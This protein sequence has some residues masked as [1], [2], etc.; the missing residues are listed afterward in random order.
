[1]AKASSLEFSNIS[2]DF[3]GVRALDEVSFTASASSVHG[4]IGENG[5]GKSTLLKILGGIYPASSGTV[6]LDGS[7]RRFEN[8]QQA[9]DAGISLIHQELQL[10]DEMTVEENLFLGHMPTRFGIIHK[11]L[12][13]RKALE[14]LEV[15]GEDI[16][17]SAK[18]R[19]LSIAKRQMV[20]V[21]KALSRG[22][23]IIAFD[24]PTSSLTEMETKRLFAII[25]G[26]KQGGV[27]VIYVSHR[28]EEV[29]R[30]CDAVTI[31][32]DGKCVDTVEVRP[33]LE[34]DELIRKMV[35]REISDIYDYRP[36][37]IGEAALQVKGLCG[38]GLTRPVDL[39]VRA[40]EIVGLFGLVGAGRTELM[41]LIYGA[42]K[43]SS[44]TVK[45]MG[46]QV[47]IN[48]P[49]DAINCGITFCPEDRK[50]EGLVA[51][52]SVKDNVNI[53]ARRL[54]TKM[55]CLVDNK[56]ELTNAE[57]MSRKLA[58]KTPSVYQQVKNLSG[59][60]QQKVILAR[61]LCEDISVMLLDEPTRGIDV[62][63]KNEIYGILFGL[64]SQ[65]KAVLVASSEMQEMLGICDRVLVVRQGGIVASVNRED[66]TEENLLK[67]ALPVS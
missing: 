59:G 42:V 18:I 67:L 20:E 5:A 29:L 55:K 65:G 13:R 64:A 27:V 50:A 36:R 52:Q 60:N 31:L 4:L 44:G 3:P 7:P 58:V 48:T 21:A 53:S 2:K 22:S 54:H 24:E 35:G 11:R 10:V 6:K 15:I 16:S 9:F 23:N 38:R 8:T 26:L 56:W 66:A 51:I 61:W 37:D 28:M 49:A 47:D 25:N 17:P 34:K 33:G 32:R 19:D 57:Q 45:V 43:K 30:I 63:A 40:G 46:R 41:K 1:M 62:G 14:Q 39:T 12:L